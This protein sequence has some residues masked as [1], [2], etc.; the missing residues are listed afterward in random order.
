MKKKLTAYTLNHFMKSRKIGEQ[1][2]DKRSDN[3]IWLCPTH[4][5][6]E[7]VRMTNFEWSEICTVIGDINFRM[8]NGL[9]VTRDA[10]NLKITKMESEPTARTNDLHDIRKSYVNL[11]NDAERTAQILEKLDESG[12]LLN[13]I[14][15]AIRSI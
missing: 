3:E 14:H 13:K 11:F 5:L 9:Y 1:W 8:E 4:E 7:T 10:H 2:M 6:A 15:S 12:Q